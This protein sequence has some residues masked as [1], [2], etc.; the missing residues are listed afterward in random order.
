M[1]RNKFPQIKTLSSLYLEGEIEYSQE[2]E[3]S[4]DGMVEFPRVILA[5]SSTSICTGRLST[6]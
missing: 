6:P 2:F 4:E 1:L 5:R 3:I